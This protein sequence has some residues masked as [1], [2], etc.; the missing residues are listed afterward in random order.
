MRCM[1]VVVIASSGKDHEMATSVIYYPRAGGKTT[2]SKIL[3][4]NLAPNEVIVRLYEEGYRVVETYIPS[5]VGDVPFGSLVLTEYNGKP[6][7]WIGGV[8]FQKQT[9]ETPQDPDD[10]EYTEDDEYDWETDTDFWDE[11]EN[12]EDDE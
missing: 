2:W 4:G 9:P 10:E 5:P 1:G 3:N 8:L 11:D 7:K 12:D 6:A